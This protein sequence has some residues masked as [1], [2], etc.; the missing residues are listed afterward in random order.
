MYLSGIY[1]YEAVTTALANAFRGKGKKATEYRKE[2]LLANLDKT[3]EEILKEKRIAFANRIRRI[4]ENFQQSR[5]KQD[6]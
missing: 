5:G 2:P 4:G 1:T 6:G 3:E